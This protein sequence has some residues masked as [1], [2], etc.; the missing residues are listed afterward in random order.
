[1]KIYVYFSAGMCYNTSYEAMSLFFVCVMYGSTVYISKYS[2]G[3]IESEFLERRGQK[4][5]IWQRNGKFLFIS[6][7]LGISNGD[8]LSSFANLHILTLWLS[9]QKGFWIGVVIEFG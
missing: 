8:T 7:F 5:V 4:S 9:R 1:M 6:N 3:R 2:C